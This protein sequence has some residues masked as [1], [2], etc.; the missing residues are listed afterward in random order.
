M[1]LIKYKKLSKYEIEDNLDKLLKLTDYQK[2]Q[3]YDKK[4]PFT[5]IIYENEEKNSLF[6]RFTII[7]YALYFLFIILFYV[8]ILWIITG[9]RYLNERNIFYKTYCYWSKKLNF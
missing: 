4:F 2:S 1:N 6:W 7:F 5:A 9:K 3:L 8:P